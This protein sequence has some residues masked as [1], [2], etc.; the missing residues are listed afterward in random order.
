MSKIE[1]LRKE[2]TFMEKENNRVYT[3]YNDLSCQLA[4]QDKSIKDYRYTLKL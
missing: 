1:M 2:N 3:K 4:D